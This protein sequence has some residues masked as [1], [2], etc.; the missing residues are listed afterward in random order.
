[1]AT[2]GAIIVA[3][4]VYAVLLPCFGAITKEE[5]KHLPIIKKFIS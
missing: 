4:V 2:I 3:A 1:L 5:L